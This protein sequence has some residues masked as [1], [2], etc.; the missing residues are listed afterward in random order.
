MK[1]ELERVYV[2]PKY[3]QC[4]T[5]KSERYGRMLLKKSKKTLERRTPVCKRRRIQP[6]HWLKSGGD[7]IVYLQLSWNEMENSV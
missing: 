1:V 2:Y 3:V 7:Q 5:G 6:V 4:I